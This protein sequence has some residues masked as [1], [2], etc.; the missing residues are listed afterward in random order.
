MDVR[1]SAYSCY[2]HIELLW[3]PPGVIVVHIDLCASPALYL[4]TGASPSKLKWELGS[5]D[6]RVFDAPRAKRAN[7]WSEFVN[8]VS[9]FVQ[10]IDD[11]IFFIKSKDPRRSSVAKVSMRS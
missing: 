9:E 11:A 5:L 2:R 1:K 7:H 3:V 10:D 8:F 6:T 4:V